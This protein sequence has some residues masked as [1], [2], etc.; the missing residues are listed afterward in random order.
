MARKYVWDMGA[1]RPPSLCLRGKKEGDSLLRSD[2]KKEESSVLN[3]IQPN[4]DSDCKGRPG[5]VPSLVV[6]GTGPAV[7]FLTCTVGA[8]GKYLHAEDPVSVHLEGE[9]PK[10][11][12]LRSRGEGSFPSLTCG[13]WRALLHSAVWHKT[14]R[15]HRSPMRG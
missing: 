2:G 14:S 5:N 13:V 3:C 8:E 9:K 11:C 7:A 15:W 6:K 4:K 12:S 1:C 10:P